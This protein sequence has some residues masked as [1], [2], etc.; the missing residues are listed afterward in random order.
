LIFEYWHGF[1]DGLLT[2]HEL[3]VWLR[4]VQRDFERLLERGEKA[5]IERLSGSCAFVANLGDS[6]R[7]TIFAGRCACTERDSERSMACCAA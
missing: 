7:W 5:N 3:Q 2:R 6:G 1:K 4:P